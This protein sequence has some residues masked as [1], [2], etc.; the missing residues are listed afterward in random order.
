VTCRAAQADDDD[1]DEEDDDFSGGA[2]SD[3]SSQVRLPEGVTSP[4]RACCGV[5]GR[6][7]RWSVHVWLRRKACA[8]APA[9]A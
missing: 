2:A 7:Q 6:A 9:L 3:S 8:R 5:V 4:R 1:S